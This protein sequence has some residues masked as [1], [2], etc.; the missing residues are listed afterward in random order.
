[1]TCAIGRRRRQA[2][3]RPARGLYDIVS[4]YTQTLIGV[5]TQSTACNAT[6]RTEQRLA[7]WLPT[8][9]RV[10][11]ISFCSRSSWR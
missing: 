10:G 1:M 11:G 4:W 5:T 7:R 9:D 6:H 8:A 2:R 3:D